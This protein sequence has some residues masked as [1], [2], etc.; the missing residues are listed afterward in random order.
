MKK[1]FWEK[2][3]RTEIE[4]LAQAGAVVIVPVGSTEQ[5][6]DHL[7]IN[8]DA[9]IC[10]QA[11]VEAAQAIDDFP[12]VVLPPLWIGYSPHHMAHPGTITLKYHTY[13]EVL[14]QIAVS[15]HAHGF[16]KIFFLN[17]HYGNSPF[18]AALRTKL[19][20][21]A[22]IPL[23]GYNYWD[24]PRV[25]ETLK[26]VCPVDKGFLGHAG[27]VETSLG[28]FLQPETVDLG[29][30][31]WVAGVWGDPSHGTAEK[32]KAIFEVIVQSLVE[33][34]KDYQSGRLEDRLVWR[35][36]IL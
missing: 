28:R 29:A 17:G 34:L 15:L 14:T 5:H 3:R 30:A 10:Y 31:A 13:M 12:V 11:A 36:Q 6:G 23:V 9:H 20:E 19:M 25:A 32:G 7:P 2:M 35:K 8:T 27:E 16:R 33:T 18:I 22:E 1:I 24:L 4:K 21:E 26:K